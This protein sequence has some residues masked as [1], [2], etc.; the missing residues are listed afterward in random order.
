MP[1]IQVNFNLYAEDVNRAIEFYT[2]NFNFEHLGDLSSDLTKRWGAL[3]T[4]NAIIWL[5]KGGASVG[6][7][8]L[9]DAE[10]EKIVQKLIENRVIFFLPEE[11][12][13]N[14]RQSEK[15]VQTNWGKHAWF[16]DSERNIVMLFEPDQG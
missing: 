8:L 4:E 12:Q 14:V 15:I 2:K 13:E 3:Q 1:R 6:L 7:V 9:V 10:I 16:I 5:G 11:F